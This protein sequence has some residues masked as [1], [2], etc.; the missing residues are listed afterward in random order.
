MDEDLQ[1]MSKDQLI[2]EAKKLRAGIREHR[3]STGQDLCRILDCFGLPSTNIYFKF[4]IAKPRND[5]DSGGLGCRFSPSVSS[6]LRGRHFKLF[7]LK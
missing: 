3:D 5:E 6:S 2:G 4:P 7:H 1:Q